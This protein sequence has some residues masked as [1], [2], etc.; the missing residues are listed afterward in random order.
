M[1]Q[2]SLGRKNIACRGSRRR[3]RKR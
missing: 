3:T 2:A 1:E